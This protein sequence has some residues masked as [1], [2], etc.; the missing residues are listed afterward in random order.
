MGHYAV[1]SDI[2]QMFHQMLV[3]NKDRNS[4]GFLQRD[5]YVGPRKDSRMG[6]HLFGKVNSL[7]IANWTI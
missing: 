6:I 3:E 4:L 2:E 7:C 5:N 1:M